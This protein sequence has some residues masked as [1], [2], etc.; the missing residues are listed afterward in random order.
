M[1]FRLVVSHSK[2]QFFIALKVLISN[3]YACPQKKVCETN[4]EVLSDAEI[5]WC[6]WEDALMS[7]IAFFVENKPF[8]RF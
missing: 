2:M 3:T 4:K 7:I 8:L 1:P 5:L 6:W